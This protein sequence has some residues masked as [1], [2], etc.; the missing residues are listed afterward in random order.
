LFWLMKDCEWENLHLYSLSPHD[1][2]SFGPLV[3]PNSALR[4]R[5]R[6]I[7]LR[8]YKKGIIMKKLKITN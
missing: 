6:V 8:S 7:R 5:N 2:S 3:P 4:S 1:G